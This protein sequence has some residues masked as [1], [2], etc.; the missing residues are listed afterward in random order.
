MVDGSP[1]LGR[2]HAQITHAQRF[3][4]SPKVLKSSK[5]FRGDAPNRAAPMLGSQCRVGLVRT[6]V[7]ERNA[8][9]HAGKSSVT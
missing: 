8:G 6:A 3:E 9:F 5:S 2:I 1:Q 7:L 4:N